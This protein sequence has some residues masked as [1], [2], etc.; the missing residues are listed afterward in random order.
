VL[1][2]IKPGERFLYI[3]IAAGDAGDGGHTAGMLIAR[4]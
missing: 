2:A 4:G 1:A 3:R